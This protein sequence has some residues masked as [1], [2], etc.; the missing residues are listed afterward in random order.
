M[1]ERLTHL[2]P[3]EGEVMELLVE[4]KTTKEIAAA[5]HVG[6]RTVEGHHGEV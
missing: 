2:T 4:G 1:T 6:V 3:R 5:L